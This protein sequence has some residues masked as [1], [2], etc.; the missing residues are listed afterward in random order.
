MR[1]DTLYFVFFLT[2][3]WFAF[4]LVPWRGWV[5]L[6]ASIVFYAVAGPRDTILA[7]VLVLINYAFQFPIMRDRRWLY[8]ALFINFGCLA[9][10]KYRVFLSTAAG[11]NLFTGNIVIPLGISFYVFQL[12]AFLIDL[13]HG[14]AQPFTSLARFCL[15]KLFFGQL[16]AG[17]IMR[18][19]KFG[20]QINRLFDRKIVPGRCRLVG[21]GLGLCLLGVTKKVVLADSLAPFVDAIFH[22]G[23]ASAAAAWL[24]AWLFLFQIYFD[25]SGYSDIALGLGLIFGMVLSR[26]FATPFLATSLPELWQRWH[27]TLTLYFRDYVFFPLAGL[28]LRGARFRVA[29]PL[30]AVVLTMALC[31]LWH[32]AG[33]NFIVWGMLQGLAMAFSTIWTRYLPKPYVALSWAATFGF[34]LVSVVFFRAANLSSAMDYLG[35]LSGFGGIGPERVPDDGAGGLLIVAGCLSLLCLHWLE[36]LLLSR[37]WVRWLLRMDGLFLRAAFAGMAIWILVI[38]KINNNPFIYFRF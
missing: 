15:F 19:S 9:Y 27:I 25:F 23:P 20:P 24:G 5:L 21:L 14:R 38:P 4:A 29:A 11:L 37:R 3:V 10:F 30:F 35:T 26:N 16:I 18:W 2:A 28:H 32:G 12:S 31:G 7:A 22:N 8:A 13:S 6:A 17:P 33:W 1:Y 36:D 34:F